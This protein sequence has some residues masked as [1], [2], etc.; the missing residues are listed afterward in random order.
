[1]PRTLTPLRYPGGKTRFYSYVKEILKC[2]N[3]LGHTYIEPFAGGAGLAIKL[4]LNNDVEYIVIND[5]D[6]SIYS[7]WKAILDKTD[8]FCDMI[9]SKDVTPEEWYRQRNI[10]MQQDHNDI[11]SL[12]FATF[13]LNRTNMSGVIKG[14]MIGGKNQGGIDK[15]DARYNKNDLVKKIQNIAARKEQ[16]CLLNL[17]AQ[18]FLQSK[19]FKKYIDAFINFDP[20]YVKKGAQLYKNSF[21]ER[22]HR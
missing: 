12:G 16:I 9:F 6:I 14:G 5:F 21:K 13:F 11:L 10:Y 18:E 15:L 7:F 20:P 17:N 2:N 8:E 4:L 22:D 1:M 3:L 19:Y